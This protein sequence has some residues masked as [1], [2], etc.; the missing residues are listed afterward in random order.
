MDSDTAIVADI[1]YMAFSFTKY[2]F[3]S[4]FELRKQIE[5]HK[6]LDGSVE[7]GVIYGKG[8]YAEGEIEGKPVLAE[9]LEMGRHV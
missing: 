1:Q 9:A 4:L 6:C 2:I 8:V 5:R 7:R 3:N